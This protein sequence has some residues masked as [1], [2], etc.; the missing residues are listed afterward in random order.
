MDQD[1]AKISAL[2]HKATDQL[3]A[4]IIPDEENNKSKDKKGK[5][6]K[7]GLRK[8]TTIQEGIKDNENKL[9]DEDTSKKLRRKNSKPL[10]GFYPHTHSAQS[11]DELD[12]ADI[13]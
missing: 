9:E 8:R 4:L 12:L 1:L 10:P 7:G 11:D 5:E 2:L 13:V 3:D 6:D